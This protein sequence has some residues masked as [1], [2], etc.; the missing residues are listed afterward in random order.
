MSLGPW[1]APPGALRQQRVRAGGA[2]PGDPP[3]SAGPP[4]TRPP[5]LCHQGKGSQSL[6][7][8]NENLVFG[9]PPAPF[10]RGTASKSINKKRK[11]LSLLVSYFF[12]LFHLNYNDFLLLSDIRKHIPFLPL[13]V[14]WFRDHTNWK[15]CRVNKVYNKGLR[16]DTH[17]K[18]VFNGWTT[19]R[20]GGGLKPP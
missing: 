19:K 12:M 5:S 13:F 18:N 9:P 7:A 11:L 1:Q 6:S 8:S 15:K 4:C 14:V 10:R 16:E 17:K 2:G 3:L 20:W